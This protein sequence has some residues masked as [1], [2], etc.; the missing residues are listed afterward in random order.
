MVFGPV[1]NDDVYRTLTLYREG[2]ITK[3]EALVRLK[4]KQ[5][6]MPDPDGGK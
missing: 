1:A 5:L 2:E 6:Y 4:I 3:D